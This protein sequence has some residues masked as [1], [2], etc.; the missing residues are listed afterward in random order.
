M[1]DV[2]VWG[3]SHLSRWIGVGA[4]DILAADIPYAGHNLIANN[5][6]PGYQVSQWMNAYLQFSS[7]PNVIVSAGTNE[8]LGIHQGIVDI[9]DVYNWWT[10]LT[11]TAKSRNQRLIWVAPL[12]VGFMSHIPA[13]TKLREWLY[14]NIVA[15]YV[16]D[17]GFHPTLAEVRPSDVH[18]TEAGSMRLSSEAVQ[19]II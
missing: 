10:C 5:A 8:A 3:D 17:S 15:G 19:R 2:E 13:V 11:R 14:L 9:D 6:V 18:Y 7:A 16:V 12:D 4:K 1:S